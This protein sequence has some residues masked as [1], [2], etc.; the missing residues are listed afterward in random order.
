M[1][2]TFF[3]ILLNFLLI[4]IAPNNY[5]IGFAGIMLI[6]FSIKIGFQVGSASFY[7]SIQESAESEGYRLYI[8]EDSKLQIER[9]YADWW[10]K[11]RKL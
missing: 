10:Y 8:D 3:M 2:T 5:W 4:L 7:H 11:K 1:R 6:V 9:K